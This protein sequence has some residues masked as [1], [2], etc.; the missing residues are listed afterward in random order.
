[1]WI[2]TGSGNQRQNIAVW[3][4]LKSHSGGKSMEIIFFSLKQDL[5]AVNSFTHDS[6]SQIEKKATQNFGS[7]GQKSHVK[8]IILCDVICVKKK[9]K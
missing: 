3:S 7:D 4:S 8:K 6:E 5:F 9:Q 2:K 1:M